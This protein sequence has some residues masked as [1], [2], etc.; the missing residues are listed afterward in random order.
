M[1]KTKKKSLPKDIEQLLELGDVAEL[2]A[3]F[4]T[5]DVNARGGFAKQTTLAFDNC[6]DELAAWLVLQ[7]ADLLAADTWGFTPLH[8]RARSRRSS[9]GVL[10]D[11]GADIHSDTS[12]LGT[13]LH[14]AASS[15]HVDN[16][17]L[18][19]NWGAEIDRPNKQGLTALELALSRCNNADLERMAKFGECLLELGA[20]RT[21]RMQELVEAIG[22]RFEFHRSGFNPD[23]IDAAS[24]GLDK[25][26]DLFS[27]QP[28]ERRVMHDSKSP[29]RVKS[30]TWQEQHQE[31]WELLVP[32]NGHA[33]TAQGEAIRITGRIFREIHHNG[34][35]NWDTDFKKMAD[36]FL[37]IV[38]RG[39]A[40]PPDDIEQTRSLVAAVKR[41]SGDPE[42]LA[43]LAVSWVLLNPAPMNMEAPSYS[44]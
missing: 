23:L 16:V 38:Q 4:D 29:I 18:L 30:N 24:T 39:H 42:R 31:L 20:K 40:L 22:K 5:C 6:P 41:K 25:L 32:S 21:A 43:Q 14:C 3:V 37:Q 34:G 11:L 15:Y 9:I 33:M 36:A 19:V 44:R 13:P 1:T 7:G 2:K 10:L 28:V 8:A 26:Y 12:S 17:R 35:N 27:V